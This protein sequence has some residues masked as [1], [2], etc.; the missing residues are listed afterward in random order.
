MTIP[1]I[2]QPQP[3]VC[4]GGVADGSSMVE[5]SAGWSAIVEWGKP[6]RR[7]VNGHP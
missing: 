4:F 7:F 2:Q 3:I 5:I 6:E 1:K